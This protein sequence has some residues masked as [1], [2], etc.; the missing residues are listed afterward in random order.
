MR[1]FA[2][3]RRVSIFGSAFYGNQGAA[4]MA[5]S[6]IATLRSHNPDL[7]IDLHSTYPRGDSSSPHGYKANIIR[8]SPIYLVLVL[9]PVA[10]L[11]KLVPR[12]RNFLARK[13]EAIDSLLKSDFLLDQMGVSFMDGREKFLIYNVAG[14]LPALILG[15]PVIKAAQA[16]GPFEGL[17][18][19]GVARIV[20]PRLS[21]IVARGRTTFDYLKNLGLEN[22][23]LGTDIV[24]SATLENDSS[25]LATE[26]EPNSCSSSKSVVFCPSTVIW[27]IREKVERGGYVKD[28]VSQIMSVRDLGLEAT[29]VPFASKPGSKSRHNND[30][31]LCQELAAKVEELA[32]DGV[33]IITTPIDYFE[34]RAMLSQAEIVITSRFHAM[35][36][37]LSC[38]IP[39]VVLGWGHKYLEIMEQF[40][41]ETS[42][43]KY[44][45]LN[46]ERFRQELVSQIESRNE[47]REIIR[48]ALPNIQSL[49]KQCLRDAIPSRAAD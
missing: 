36:T 11:I 29:V 22:I 46:S 21:A 42:V 17:L 3:L 15:T 16:L 41:L 35:V 12:L 49:S 27:G 43:F 30:L 23:V 40:G 28:L 37:S 20:L 13:V 14:V 2:S 45:V 32:I 33:K 26:D 18:N 6:A 34:A 8:S 4:A 24:F 10:L 7:I 1:D 47:T 38:G 5:L 48:R 44:K 9:I 25:L 31:P 39:V 19:R